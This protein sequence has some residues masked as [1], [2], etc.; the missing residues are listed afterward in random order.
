MP[1]RPIVPA[2]LGAPL[3]MYSHGVVAPAG[4]LVVV[5]GQVGTRADG[6]LAGPDV[7]A[8]TRQA[9]EN[10]RTVLEAAGCSMRDVVRF[11]TFLTSADD[12]PG[13]MKARGEYR[14]R[15]RL[16]RVQA[17]RSPIIM[18][19]VDTSNLDDEEQPAIRNVTAQVMSLNK[20]FRLIAVS[21]F[22]PPQPS[23]VSRVH[24]DHLVRLRHWIDPIAITR[25]RLSL[26]AIESTD[27]AEALVDFARLNHVDLIIVGGP[28]ASAV[29]AN[30][31]CSVHV[32]R[33]PE[34]TI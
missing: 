32:V 7:G 15:P 30:A 29:A 22:E 4:D 21:V 17:S 1:P 26:H 10:V 14:T 8:Q 5:A 18:V 13:F 23:D 24:V 6:S 11:Q 25:Q 28:V 19:A 20:E 2:K 9:L 12:L 31:P 16:P 3:G 33:V 34:V 27:P